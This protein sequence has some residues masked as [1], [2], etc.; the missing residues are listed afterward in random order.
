MFLY[1]CNI[2]PRGFVAAF[3]YIN[4]SALSLELK[5]FFIHILNQPIINKKKKRKNHFKIEFPKFSYPPKE[6]KSTFCTKRRTRERIEKHNKKFISEAEQQKTHL[7]KFPGV[8][9]NAVGDQS[10][11]VLGGSGVLQRLAEYSGAE[12]EL[13]SVQQRRVSLVAA[14][15]RLSDGKPSTECQ[16]HHREQPCLMR[17]H[18]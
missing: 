12:Q 2:P 7:K 9:G 13:V 10:H 14:P 15:T 18:F 5:L 8:S 3:L 4:F 11:H 17:T 16:H 1:G 6:K